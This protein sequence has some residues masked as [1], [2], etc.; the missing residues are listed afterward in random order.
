MFEWHDKEEGF[1]LP[2]VWIH[3]TVMHKNFRE[4]LNLWAIGMML[5]STQT[6]DMKTMCNNNFG[7]L[8]W[9]CWIPSCC[10]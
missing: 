8:L 2:K 1:L 10:H 5:G 6:V 3:V 4:F 7:E 9:A